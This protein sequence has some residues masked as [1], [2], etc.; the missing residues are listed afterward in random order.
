MFRKISYKFLKINVIQVK[1]I[2]PIDSQEHEKS[3]RVKVVMKEIR[4]EI[5]KTE[6]LLYQM[7]PKPVARMLRKC[8]RN[9]LET[10]KVLE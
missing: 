10:C 8:G 5:T 4:Y 7:L 3:K 9:S 2:T 6:E 1:L